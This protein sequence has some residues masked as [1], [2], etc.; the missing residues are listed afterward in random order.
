MT[1]SARVTLLCSLPPALGFIFF[2][3]WFLD[4]AFPPA[5]TAAA[6]AL[7]ILSLGQLV[8]AAMGSAGTLLT[9][10]RRERQAAFGVTV[11]AVVTVVVSAALI[12]WLGVEGAAWAGALSLTT[13]NIWLAIVARRELGIDTTALGLHPGGASRHN[14]GERRPSDA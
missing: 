13:W 5:F 14:V 8:N 3:S 4:L 6:P 7:A 10:A 11:G 2:G 12:P 1:L 9:M